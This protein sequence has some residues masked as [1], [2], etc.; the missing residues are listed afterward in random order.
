MR[1]EEN[2]RF[3]SPTQHPIVMFLHL[4]ILVVLSA[5]AI[6]LGKLKINIFGGILG[7]WEVFWGVVYWYPA[8]TLY[9]LS[10]TIS[11]KLP[12]DLMRRIDPFRRIPICIAYVWA[13]LSYNVFGMWPAVEGKENL[14]VLREVDGNGKKG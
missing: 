3:H 2:K 9:G 11:S 4:C 6:T 12:G 14:E 13:L 10:R 8:M 5:P 7:L 1:K